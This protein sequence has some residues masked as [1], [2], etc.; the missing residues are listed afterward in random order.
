MA[1]PPDGPQRRQRAAARPAC[2]VQPVS[3]RGVVVERHQEVLVGRVEQ[4]EEKPLD[5]RARVLDPLAE[6]AVADVEQHAQADRHAFVGELRDLL[7]SPS[8]YISNASRGSPVTSVL[9]VATVAV[10]L[11]SSTPVWNGCGSRIAGCCAAPSV[12]A[13]AMR[14]ATKTA[15]NP[16]L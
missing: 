12:S 4:L 15:T 13:P 14:T 5:R 11:V 1:V 2:V 3:R 16:A 6:H 7:A 8:S 10:M 9:L